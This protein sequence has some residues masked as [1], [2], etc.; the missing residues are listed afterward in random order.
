MQTTAE[1]FQKLEKVVYLPEEVLNYPFLENIPETPEVINP[2]KQWE[3]IR[4]AMKKNGYPLYY[5]EL[6]NF[7]ELGY[8][9]Q[10]F[11]PGLDRF[12]LIR[13]GNLVA[14]QA[15]LRETL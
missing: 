8:V 3:D 11:A 9:V 13:S 7:D 15:T 5:T 6:A 4:H 12:H 1:Q 14:S 10:V 2:E